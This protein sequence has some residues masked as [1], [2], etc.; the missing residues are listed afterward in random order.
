[1]DGTVQEEVYQ[2]RQCEKV[3]LDIL[4]SAGVLPQGVFSV[5]I[6]LTSNEVLSPGFVKSPT[7]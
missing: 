7:P 2:R 5:H 6:C 1:M 3:G 4:Y